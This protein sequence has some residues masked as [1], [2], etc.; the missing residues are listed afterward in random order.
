LA[1]EGA[2]VAEDSEGEAVGDEAPEVGV[3]AV[4]E[5]LKEACGVVRAA[6]VTPEVGRSRSTPA[7]MRWRQ[8]GPW[9]WE[10]GKVRPS[11]SMGAEGP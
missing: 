10:S 11:A 4:E 8:T 9:R 1:G 5:I 2:E 7:P 6:P 3:G